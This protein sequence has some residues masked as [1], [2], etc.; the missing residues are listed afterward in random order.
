MFSRLRFQNQIWEFRNLIGQIKKIWKLDAKYHFKWK[1][2]QICLF[3]DSDELFLTNFTV[4]I[5]ISFINH[6]LQLL[7]WHGFA[8]LS[9]DSFK[10]FKWDFSCW[11]II[12]K[13]E[14][15]ENFLSWI[16]FA[17]FGSHKFHKVSKL[18][19]TF[20]ISINFCD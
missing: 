11:V 7:F 1:S 18:N 19:Y 12:E 6:F 10:I 3:H 16:S 2:E 13:S 8:Q 17:N 5:S 9:C 4:S 14:C 15:F 20:S